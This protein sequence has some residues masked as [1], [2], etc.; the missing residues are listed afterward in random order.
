MFVILLEFEKHNQPS[1][2]FIRDTIDVSE[3]DSR[4]QEMRYHY[5]VVI[6]LKNLENNKSRIHRYTDF[7]NRWINKATNTAYNGA[8]YIVPFLNYIHFELSKK[9]L[10]SIQD[11]TFEHGIAYLEMRSQKSSWLT[12]KA[13]EKTLD[14]FYYFLAEKG[15][16]NNIK[17]SDFVYLGA[18]NGK[19]QLES[20]FRG[21]YYLPNKG[22]QQDKL[23]QIENSLIFEF[24]LTALQYHPQIALGIYFQIFGG[25]RVGEIVNLE[26]KKINPRGPFGRNGMVLVISNS[27]LRRDL[28]ETAIT[29]SKKPRNQPI[30]TFGSL[31]EE[32]YKNHKKEYRKMTS[33][34]VFIDRNGNAMSR[35]TYTYHFNMVKEKFVEKLKKSENPDHK[36]Y[37]SFLV[38]QKW[39]TH[40]G[41]GIFSSIV[42]ET[43]DNASEIAV[44]RGDTDLRSALIYLSDS[45]R[46]EGKISGKLNDFYVDE[47]K[48]RLLET[49]NDT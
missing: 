8:G 45:Q 3:L 33:D 49:M 37:A 42:A 18:Q 1:L 28:R 44:L 16:L 13:I 2:Q 34:A 22:K 35:S 23:H 21:K 39:S 27:Y 47:M 17:K 5:R 15:I 4:T 20:H 40:I 24:I 48:K 9:E 46:L 12:M 38:T 36:L 31:L 25:L 19:R 29:S 26:Y 32:L 7:L 14:K 11:L 43:A 30:L 6:K 41:R 10:P